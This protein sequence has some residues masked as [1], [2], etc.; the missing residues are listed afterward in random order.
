MSNASIQQFQHEQFGI[1]RTTTIDG[2]PW[3]V[4]KDVCDALDLK[5][6][7]SSIALLDEDEKGVTT[8]NTLGGEQQ[9]L[10]ISEAGLY[11]LVLR[12]RKPEA[13][14]FKRWVTHEVLPSIRKTGRYIAG[15]ESM[16]PEQMVKASM[17][18]LEAR[19]SEQEQQIELQNEMINVMRPKALFADAVSMSATSIP[20]GDLAKVLKRGGTNIGRNRLMRLMRNDGYLMKQRSSKNMPTQK[21]MNLG[22]LYIEEKTVVDGS[23]K[24]LISKRTMVTGK[25]QTYFHRLYCISPQ[26]QLPLP[27]LQLPL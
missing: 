16:T 23:G 22:L 15:Q 26:L 18:W 5:N 14:A 20:I 9:M 13:K 27:Q 8:S 11:S 25:G 6:T 3:F 4:A 2:E 7:R 21:A 12:S 17:Q 10:T 19:I 1:I 24:S